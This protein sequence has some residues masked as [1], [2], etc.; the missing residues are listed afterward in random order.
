MR[1]RPS[2]LSLLVVVCLT[3]A[4]LAAPFLSAA[5]A[6]PY[7][8]HVYQANPYIVA[9][10][11]SYPVYSGSTVAQSFLVNQTYALQNVTLRVLNQGNKF[12]ALN[13]SIHPDDPV[14]HFPV[15]STT[16]AYRQEVTSTNTSLP[17]NAN[18]PFSPTPV[19]RKGQ[20]YWIVAQNTASSI[21]S[22]YE[23]YSTNG[24]TYPDGQAMIGSPSW[25]GLPVD[26]F[27]I[28]FGQEVDA[29]VT[30]AITANRT[31][32][33]P[34]DPVTFTVG[35][36][37]T[38]ASTASWVWVN[39]T[40]P[41][42]L[43]NV[44]V[45]FPGIQPV[46]AATFPD[47][48]FSNVANGPHSFT[49]AAQVAIG[50]PPG[51]L[52]TYSAA[53]AYT[54]GTGVV[55]QAGTAEASVHVGLVTK[56]M[57]LGGTSATA[58]QLSTTTPT[59]TTPQ[60]VSLAQ[61]T[62]EATFVLSPALARPLHVC[63]VS[64]TLWVRPQHPPPQTY[65]VTLDLLDNGASVASLS[66]SF[67]LTT[68]TLVPLSFNF[69][70]ANSTFG[71][72]HA[73]G[74][75]IT[76]LGGAGGSTDTL[77]LGY[78][79]TSNDSQVDVLTD[80]YVAIENLTLSNQEGLTSAWST[81]DSLVVEANVSDPFGASR[82]EGAWVN[83]TDPSGHLAAAGPMSA[84]LAD[85]SSLPAWELFGFTL[86]PPLAV[87][88][89]RVVVTA[90]EDNGVTTLAQAW[91]WVAAPVMRFSAIPSTDRVQTGQTFAL[92]LYYNNTGTG[93]AGPAWINDT[94]PAGLAYVTSG[95]PY[96][97]AAG[98]TYTWSFPDVPVGTNVLELDLRVNATFAAWVQNAASLAFQDT[99]GHPLG[100]LW[101]N[102]SVLLNGPRIAL[103]M[104]SLP[105]TTVH[106]NETVTYTLGLANTG[107]AAGMMW[108]NATLPAGFTYKDSTAA[109]LGGAVTITGGLV[110]IALPGMP[111]NTTWQFSLVATAGPALVRNATYSLATDLTYTNATGTLMPVDHDTLAL[112]AA[113]PWIPAVAVSF[114][115]NPVLAG[116]EVPVVV[117]FANQ[118]NEPASRVW[119]NLTWGSQLIL[120]N[121]SEPYTLSPSGA[122]FA[123]R[124][125][126]VGSFDLSLN[127]TVSPN[128]TDRSVL[129]VAGTLDAQ[130]AIQNPLPTITIPATSLLVVAAQ[131]SLTVTPQS[132]MFEA[133][134]PYP[135]Q[136]SFDNWGHDIAVNLFLDLTL[137][138]SLTYVN[139]SS[140]TPPTM[141]GSSYTWY[142]AALP[143]G[144]LSFKLWV[145]A[146]AG[147][148]SGTA[149]ALAFQLNY[150]NSNHVSRPALSAE[151]TGT[152]G[153]PALTLSVV[154]SALAPTT[155]HAVVYTA[156]VT[157]HGLVAA[158]TVYL[159]DAVDPRL[160]VVTYD[161][162]VTATED[163]GILNW[164]FTAL[165]P[166]AT[167]VIN[168]TVEV[169]GGV[170][171]GTIIPTVFE[172]TYTN[173]V[174]AVLGRVRST[175]V[176][177][178][179][180]ADYT[181][182]LWLGLGAAGFA[183]LAV[184]LLRW[185]RVDIEDVFL[186]YRDGVLISHLSRTLLRDKD[187]DV[188][189][190]ML[191][192]VQEFVREAFQYG[193]HRD[194]HQ[195]DF[196]D[197]RILIERGKY[198]FLAV[199]YAGKESLT[200]RKKVRAVIERVET[201]FGATLEAW[202]GDMER[203]VGARDLV[204]DT[205]LGS[206][207]HNHAPRLAPESE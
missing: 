153:A 103:S 18:W 102:T 64:G 170:A 125:V 36:N 172:A 166:G 148:S 174:G 130:D 165:A 69:G 151:L 67:T 55:V 79:S 17:S 128:T 106:G 86:N 60:A 4:G 78:N 152:V 66:P 74:L 20:T 175:P 76:N 121:A 141:S 115:M 97:S 154:V 180:S 146:R 71:A 44:S 114:A 167:E 89:Y 129:S 105:A 65:R 135:L 13:V 11:Q 140:S 136:V 195:L 159:V 12:N 83:I 110:Q 143:P 187:E 158:G 176:T 87:G 15:M 35:L 204:R 127:F 182:L 116:T 157:N 200:L 108:L 16:L 30:P 61:G 48:V 39:D 43:V 84:L 203:V 113:S 119:V 49:V 173:S 33:Q 197:Y 57:Y 31:Q 9:G 14:T 46:S 75:Q 42:D 189:S 80:T 133:G 59:R 155:G 199:V 8:S 185:R 85:P 34:G 68:S 111:A 138:A 117:T 112:V 194:L 73:I 178:T 32:L 123:L 183:L 10:A 21:N 171:A 47:L 206:G 120:D 145:E 179:V 164:T 5:T 201:E 52:L 107:A 62:G 177:V 2:A 94:L 109:E 162:S 124:N 139:D 169:A 98:S 207:N 29:N 131:I 37:N 51:S 25:A 142:W 93:P 122:E 6:A 96:T 163:N 188:L 161:S 168:L 198:V 147:V 144:A 58:L 28:T 77:N 137:P 7:G 156:R 126:T 70:I 101:S 149:A 193:E 38:G 186:V 132:P 19:L 92:F 23:W 192:A 72:G 50:T 196:G 134:V 184:V 1:R 100:F 3:A 63:N 205:L 54:N 22:G 56:E 82:I 90:M 160:Q 191:T 181:A 91:A 118:G 27:F 150:E 81:L 53:L 40:L 88:L 190:G 99:S 24:T 95:V 202:D 104:T 26:M 41:A 45:A